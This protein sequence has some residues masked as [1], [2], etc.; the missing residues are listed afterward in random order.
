MRYDSSSSPRKLSQTEHQNEDTGFS[1]SM[2]LVSSIAGITEA[3][4]LF[5]YSSAKHGVIG[6]MRALRPWAPVKYNVRVNAI[7]PWATDTQ[8]LA[9][10][11][12]RWVEEDMPL[13]QPEDVA[14]MILQSAADG[15]LHGK[16]IYV[17]GGKGFDTEE[18]YDRCLPQWMGETN[19]KM[20]LKGQEILGLVSWIILHRLLLTL[21]PGR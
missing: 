9:G 2:I 11:K 19:A 10:V 7:C 20:W 4:G 13:N 18:G 21:A 15:Q 3:P 17:A 14:K 12:R 6:L 5:A 16:A 8:I 1:K